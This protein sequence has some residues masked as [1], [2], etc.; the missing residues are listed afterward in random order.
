MDKNRIPCN[1]YKDN[2]YK[3]HNICKDKNHI[4][5]SI[6]IAIQ[7]SHIWNTPGLSP[8]NHP[9][10]L[11]DGNIHKFDILPHSFLLRRMYNKIWDRNY[12]ESY[13]IRHSDYKYKHK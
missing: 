5:R 12:K 6:C 11:H 3:Q 4:F 10:N 7:D 9:H 13:H 8:H 2:L 1:I